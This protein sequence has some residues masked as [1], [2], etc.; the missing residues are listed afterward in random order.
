MS[1]A[2]TVGGTVIRQDFQTEQYEAEALPRTHPK[3]ADAR[4]LHY[5]SMDMAVPRE[6]ILSPMEPGHAI[7]IWDG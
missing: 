5:C 6:M 7:W 1:T 4:V 3:F 2:A